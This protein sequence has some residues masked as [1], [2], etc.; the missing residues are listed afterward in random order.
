MQSTQSPLGIISGLGALPVEVAQSA[1]ER[2][3]PV[4]VVRLKGFEEPALEKFPGA[5]IGMAEVGKLFKAFKQ[6]GCKDI[7]FCGIVK[8]PDFSALKPD[9]RGLSLLPKVIS[10]ARKGDDA[11]LRFLVQTF[12]AE[13]FRVIGADEASGALRVGAGAQSG[14]D[15]VGPH[16]ADLKKAAIMAAEIGRLDIG[17]G[18]IVCDGLVLGVEAQEG[19]D[20]MLKRIAALDPAIRGSETQ[21]RGVLVK[22][23]K[24][25]QERRIDLPTIGAATVEN[26][27][28]AGL[29]GIGVEAGGALLINQAEVIAQ[30]KAHGMFLYGF[31]KD[32][33]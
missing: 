15:L 6:A 26:A 17:Q 23:P 4:F 27:A 29:A 32:W 25:M 2:G 31:G 24:P 16:M 11:L 14:E 33:P 28:K 21:K 30:L 8:R 7:C 20:E 12:E 5:T 22:R 10:V 1:I 13:G 18:A 9:M 3:Q 19:T